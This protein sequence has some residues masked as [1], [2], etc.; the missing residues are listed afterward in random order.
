MPIIVSAEVYPELEINTKYNSQQEARRVA[1]QLSLSFDRPNSSCTKAFDG[2]NLK[3]LSLPSAVFS[4]KAEL[5]ELEKRRDIAFDFLKKKCPTRVGVGAMFTRQSMIFMC[6]YYI[7]KEF[8]PSVI[9][10]IN[11]QEAAISD[12]ETYSRRC[13]LRMRNGARC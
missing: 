1:H 7:D 10:Q 9:G 13:V 6:D 8:L 11:L 3:I 5:V 2:S 4:C 12:L